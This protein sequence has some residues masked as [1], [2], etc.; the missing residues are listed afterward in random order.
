MKGLLLVGVAAAAMSATFTLHSAEKESAAFTLY[1][2]MS[3][4][5]GTATSL[6]SRFSTF[7]E[8]DAL[9]EFSSEKR[10]IFMILVK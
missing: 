7:V 3:S 8:S 5:Y 6:L 9:S 10:P 4:D 1:T 2:G